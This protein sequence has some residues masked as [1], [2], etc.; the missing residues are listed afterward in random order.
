MAFSSSFRVLVLS[1]GWVVLTLGVGC[2]APSEPV[3]LFGGFDYEWEFLSHRISYL[4]AQVA[5]PDDEGVIQ[6]QAGIIGGPFSLNPAAPEGVR[7]SLGWARVTST[8]VRAHYGTMELDIGPTGRAEATI[9]LDRASLPEADRY[10]V[11]IQG[12]LLDTDVPQGQEFPEEYDPIDGWTPQALGA[13]V[14]LPGSEPAP[15]PAGGNVEV[16][17]TGEGDLLVRGWLEFKPGPLDREL[18]NEAMEFATIGG[19]LHYVVIGV[20]DAQLTTGLL[21]TGAYYSISG[22]PYTD[23]PPL[24]E[25]DRRLSLQGQA[26]LPL[27]M[28]LLHSFRVELNRELGGEGRYLRALALEV[29]SFEYSAGT[30]AAEL[31]LDAYCSHSSLIEEGDLQVEFRARLGLLQV[32]DHD[33][34]LERGSLQGDQSA[35]PFELTTPS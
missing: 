1:L 15:L 6:A 35:G 30:G 11:A 10:V 34:T 17:G 25:V 24:A 12:L 23:I 9:S 16:D 18:M 5:D 2:A 21:E 7:Y 33:G 3:S 29:E 22:S 19:Q 28:P 20:D 4:R 31:T 27:A 8:H 26:G 13:G 14:D 32:N